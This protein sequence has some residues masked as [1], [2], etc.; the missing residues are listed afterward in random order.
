[1]GVKRNRTVAGDRGFN[2]MAWNE[3]VQ[4][5][6]HVPPGAGV[7]GRSVR[8]V[9]AALIRYMNMDGTGAFPSLPTLARKSAASVSTVQRALGILADQG[10]LDWVRG[11]GRPGERGQPNVYVPMI[12]A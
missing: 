2:K 12:P 1:M 8:A 5:W 11:H 10:Y 3:R 4:D 6:V 9:S 7:S